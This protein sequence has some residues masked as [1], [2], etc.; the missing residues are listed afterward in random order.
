MKAT[1]EEMEQ[2]ARSQFPG[3]SDQKYQELAEKN[4]IGFE[5]HLSN[6]LRTDL[7]AMRKSLTLS[8]FS[9]INNSSLMYSHYADGHRGLCL[10]FKVIKHA[11]FEALLPVQYPD[12]FPSLGFFE[13]DLR[14]MMN[15]QLLTKQPEWKY[16]KEYRIIKVDVP[17]NFQKFPPEALT[18][19]IFGLRTNDADITLIRELTSH[20][21]PEI[22]LYKCTKLEGSFNLAIIP[23][24]S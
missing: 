15:A 1:R 6:S 10:E 3:L 14:G 21:K 7:D 23:I 19:I 13:R 12:Q 8:C 22:R 2:F 16:E 9:Q 5:D 17:A 18:G 20:R 4:L 11:F 24:L